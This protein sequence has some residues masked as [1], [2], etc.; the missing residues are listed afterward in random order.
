VIDGRYLSSVDD[1]FLAGLWRNRSAAV[2]NAPMAV[3]G[4]TT[5]DSRYAALATNPFSRQDAERE[6]LW[7]QAPGR[8]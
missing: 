1:L 6:W 8:T 3:H 4:A 5:T 2:A 7:V